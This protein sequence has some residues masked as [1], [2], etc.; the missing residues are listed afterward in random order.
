MKKAVC[1]LLAAA[2][3][4]IF[5]ACGDSIDT[6]VSDTGTPDGKW[7]LVGGIRDGKEVK[8]GKKGW[9][10]SFDID[11]TSGT[12]YVADDGQDGTFNVT[13]RQLDDNEYEIRMKD[14]IAIGTATVGSDK[15]VYE[16]TLGSEHDKYV[17]KK[18]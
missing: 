12:Y 11:G 6:S 8:A 4:G 16:S 9:D 14:T 7:E 15:M 17:Y 10:E 3:A 2:C 13:F 1:V 18:V 5:T